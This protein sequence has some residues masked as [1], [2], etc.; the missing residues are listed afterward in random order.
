MLLRILASRPLTLPMPIFFKNNLGFLG[1][2]FS[3]FPLKKLQ[4]IFK[5]DVFSAL[6]KKIPLY[7]YF[8][9]SAVLLKTLEPWRLHSS[10]IARWKDLKE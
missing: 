5:N 8:T 3:V 7:M 10:S 1:V 9:L 6:S 4:K 2:D